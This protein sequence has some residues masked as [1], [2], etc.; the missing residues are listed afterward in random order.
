MGQPVNRPESKSMGVVLTQV[1]FYH[2]GS[3]H[4]VD[5]QPCVKMLANANLNTDTRFALAFGSRNDEQSG[6]QCANQALCP[7]T[8]QLQNPP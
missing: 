6:G 2:K 5:E 4:K 8:R 1:H 3:L 7:T